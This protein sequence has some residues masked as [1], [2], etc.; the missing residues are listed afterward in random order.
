MSGR[1]SPSSK[2]KLKAPAKT[3]YEVGYGRPPKETRFKPGMSGNPSGRPKGAKNKLPALNEERLKTIIMEEAYRTITVNEGSKP[4]T[5]PM[6]KAIV[7]SV[8]VNAAKG[9][10]RAQRLFME[11]LSATE[12]DNKRLHDQWLETAINYKIEWEWE[13]LHREQT[14]ASGPDPLPHPDDIE[15]DMRSGEVRVNGP[16]TKEEKATWDR[17]RKRKADCDRAIAELEQLIAD[18]PDY[19]HK[20]L[21]LRD[22]EFEHQ[23]RDIICRV[24]PD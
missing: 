13:L 8:A 19:E 16:W 20:E 10:A 1:S 11:M 14:G 4:V 22:I 17:L 23:I 9:N 24:I 21:V 15:I 12:R 18:D 3:D 5:V 6:A 7:R 2:A